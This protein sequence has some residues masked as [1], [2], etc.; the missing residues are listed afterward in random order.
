MPSPPTAI[1]P[2]V[3]V[4]R[5]FVNTV[6]RRDGTE[7]LDGPVALQRWLRS[8]RLIPVGVPA[9]GRDLRHALR[10]RSALRDDLAA[11][12]AT[13]AGPAAQAALDAVYRELPLTAVSGPAAL[14]PTATGVQGALA[15]IVAH[16]TT[17]RIRGTWARLKVCVAEDCRRAFYD[18]SRHRNR[19]CCPDDV[20]SPPGARGR[21][22][23]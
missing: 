17:A 21:S 9:S 22:T 2:E 8:T 18:T 19:R 6:D 7:L 5:S 13:R 15:Q 4:V 3:E 20:C 16:A 23:A 11:N 14:V 12:G 1:P 10:L